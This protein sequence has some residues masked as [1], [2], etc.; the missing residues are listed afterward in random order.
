MR[1]FIIQLTGNPG[2]ALASQAHLAT[3]QSMQMAYGSLAVYPATP[4]YIIQQMAWTQ[5]NVT[6][7]GFQTIT[8][9]D[10]LWH[11]G[12][13]NSGTGL[14]YSTDGKTWTL[15]NLP[16]GKSSFNDYGTY[17]AITKANDVWVTGEFGQNNYCT[18][19]YYSADGKNWTQSNVTNESIVFVENA[20]GLWVVGSRG[21]GNYGSSCG[22]YYSTDGKTW[23]PSNVSDQGVT[24]AANANGLLVAS[25]YDGLYYS[26]ITEVQFF[27]GEI[28][29]AM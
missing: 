27:L 6:T 17:S 16:S 21:T 7:G 11:A 2:R 24:F 22:L 29:K 15:S 1:D 10:G 20:N 13:Y 14:Y 28:K 5:S 4:G 23:M 3:R 19:L 25:G 12:G 9:T 26:T 8:Y 18:G